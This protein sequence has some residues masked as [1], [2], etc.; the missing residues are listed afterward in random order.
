MNATENEPAQENSE[1]E[2]SSIGESGHTREQTQKFVVVGEP[3]A[4]GRRRGRATQQVLIE[5]KF[6]RRNNV[7]TLD[8][9]IREHAR[10][11]VLVRNGEIAL[12]RGEVLG[13][14]YGRHREL[15]SARDEIKTLQTL[16]EQLQVL[17][18]EKTGQRLID[19]AQRE[20]RK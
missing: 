20:R 18:D 9:L 6:Q 19:D 16:K 8:G 14:G 11:L 17:V 7:N 3:A 15:L 12:D 13:R 10:L 4:P 1:L 5:R 2:K